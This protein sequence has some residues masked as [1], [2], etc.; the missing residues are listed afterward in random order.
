MWWGGPSALIR[1]IARPD[2][3]SFSISL[4]LLI[5]LSFSPSSVA[6]CV[7]VAFFERRSNEVN[8]Q[9]NKQ[10]ILKFD[11]LFAI[12]VLEKAIASTN[13]KSFMNA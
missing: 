5:F 12:F 1:A 2:C 9:T 4:S 8:K 10:F 11:Y 13:D 3:R 6:F 7:C